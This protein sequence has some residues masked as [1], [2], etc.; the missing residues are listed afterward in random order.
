MSFFNHNSSDFKNN[1]RIFLNYLGL[2]H[3][4]EFAV[5]QTSRSLSGGDFRQEL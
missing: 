5:K 2:W 4:S 3:T 1:D